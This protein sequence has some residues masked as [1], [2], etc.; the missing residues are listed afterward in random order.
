[1]I[2]NTIWTDLNMLY[3]KLTIVDDHY[4]VRVHDSV[5]TM[6]NC[7]DSTVFKLF[8]DKVLNKSVGPVSNKNKL[9]IILLLT[10][11]IRFFF[12]YSKSM[13]AV[14]SSKIN[15]RFWSKATLARQTICLWPT[16]RLV[17]PSE[18]GKSN[19]LWFPTS[20]YDDPIDRSSLTS[21]IADQRTWS[22][23]LPVGSKLNLKEPRNKV[24]SWEIR[25]IF[26]RSSWSPI[27]LTSIPSIVI[28]PSDSVRRSSAA[29]MDVFPAPLLPTIPIFK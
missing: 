28:F 12:H 7:Q 26:E 25:D 24:G 6:G 23:N 19:K 8:S 21:F 14:A 16:E 10:H 29:M 20:L 13:L 22:A 9:T 27:I 1:M 3:Q 4:L 2:S 5:Q 11:N 18:T 15:M 17:P